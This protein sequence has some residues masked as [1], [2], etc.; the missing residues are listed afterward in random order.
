MSFAES[1]DRGGGTPAKVWVLAALAKLFHGSQTWSDMQLLGARSV[2]KG[3]IFK[4]KIESKSQ[5]E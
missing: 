5:N 3:I 2:S 4:N 1:M